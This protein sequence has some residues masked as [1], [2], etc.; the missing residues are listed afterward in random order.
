M[1]VSELRLEEIA[2]LD[3]LIDRLGELDSRQA[4]IVE[5]RFFGGLSVALAH[6][7]YSLYERPMVERGRRFI[8]RQR[9]RMMPMVLRY[10][11][12]TPPG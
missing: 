3:Q 10:P 2:Y 7:S 8:D 11:D 9:R 6:L 4:R 1:L 5:L 12:G